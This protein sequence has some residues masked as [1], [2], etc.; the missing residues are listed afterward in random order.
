MRSLGAENISV[1]IGPCIKQMS[2]EID[3]IFYS[4]FIDQDP[5]N[6]EFFVPGDRADHYLFDLPS[7]VKSILAQL[8]IN[9]VIDI[10]VNTYTDKENCFSFRRFT[11]DNT[12]KMGNLLSLIMIEK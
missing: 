9:D 3:K 12:N 5:S 6:R 11:H 4:K 2:Y 1:L 7:Y 8:M 10:D